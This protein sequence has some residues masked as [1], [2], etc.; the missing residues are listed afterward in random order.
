MSTLLKVAVDQA[1]AKRERRILLGV[2]GSPAVELMFKTATAEVVGRC[3]KS[4]KRLHPKDEMMAAH[5]ANLAVL[6]SCC[7]EIWQNGVTT[8]LESGDPA[9][10]TDREVQADVGVATASEAVAVVV[11]LDGDVNALASALL[12][13]SGFDPDGTPLESAENPI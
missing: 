11:G 2:P 12:R 10:F 1:N 13:A 6:A 7:T 5:Q 4:G 3:Q 8:V 9:T